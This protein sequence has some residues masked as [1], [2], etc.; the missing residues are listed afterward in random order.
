MPRTDGLQLTAWVRAHPQL[1]RLA[2]I[3][4]SGLERE[5]DIRRGRQAGANDYIP[6]SQLTPERLIGA[7]ER[8]LPRTDKMASAA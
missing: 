1:Q 7:V 2:V 6:R 8:C 3:L 4:V 5:A